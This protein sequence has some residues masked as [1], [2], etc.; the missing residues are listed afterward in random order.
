MKT[1]TSIIIADSQRL[2]REGL[3]EIL[4]AV[5]EFEVIGEAA[6]GREAVD[7][8]AAKR[9]D[10]VVIESQ[11]PRLSGI[12]AVRRIC[13]TNRGTACIV[14]STAYGPVHVKQA[15]VAGAS[16]FVPKDAAAQDLVDA[17]WSVRSGRSYLAPAVAD[18]VVSALKAPSG[19]L[20]GPNGDLT[21]RQRE[22][23]QLIAEGL[24]TKEIANELGISLKTAQTHRANVMGRVGV[25]KVSGLVRFA[26]REGIVSV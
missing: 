5:P 25:H 19:S 11:L 8:V 14:V 7:L 23:L 17:V 12:E 21:T 2:I 18:Q 26:I 3:R 9:P 10:V 1:E 13:E 22:V 15:L 4:G 24:S 20:S 6:N 16:G